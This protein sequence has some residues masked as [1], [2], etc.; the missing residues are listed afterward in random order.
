MNR[1]AG[2]W[3]QAQKDLTGKL[4][5]EI[6]CLPEHENAMRRMIQGWQKVFGLSVNLQSLRSTARLFPRACRTATIR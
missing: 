4:S 6:I 2:Y 5:L 1:S 3:A